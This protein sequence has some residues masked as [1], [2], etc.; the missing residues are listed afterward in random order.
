VNVDFNVDVEAQNVSGL[1][2]EV[3]RLEGRTPL[4]FIT[5]PTS[6]KGFDRTVLL[7]GHLDKV[8][9]HIHQYE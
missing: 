6:S 9:Y 5:V 4:I 1:E 8:A 3:L 7:Y 2:L